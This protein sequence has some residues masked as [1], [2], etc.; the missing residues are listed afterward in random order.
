[1]TYTIGWNNQ[2]VKFLKKLPV[3]IANRIIHKIES[4][5]DDPFHYLEHYEGADVYKLRIGDYRALI[6]VDFASKILKV[7]V[8]GNRGNIYNRKLE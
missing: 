2:P 3:S 1:M 7:R 5:T 4:I 8:I 6:E